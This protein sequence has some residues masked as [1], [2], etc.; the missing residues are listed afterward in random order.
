AVA[1][2]RRAPRID[3]FLQGQRQTLQ[4]AQSGS[5]EALPELPRDINA[6]S[7]AAYIR[8]VL[9]GS[10]PIPAPIATQVAHIVHAEKRLQETPP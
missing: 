1:E 4:E 7:T 6:A 9:A 8:A 2:P 5:L 3:L 10:S